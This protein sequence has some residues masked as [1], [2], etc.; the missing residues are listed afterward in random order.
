VRTRAGGARVRLGDHPVA[1]ELREL[2]LD[3]ARAVT[4]T[5]VAHVSMIFGPAE[6][7]RT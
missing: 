7:V 5:T 2:G 3:R 6:E 1:D 4:A